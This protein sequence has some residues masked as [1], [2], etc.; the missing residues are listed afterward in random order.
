MIIEVVLHID[1]PEEWTEAYDLSTSEKIIETLEAIGV[2]E[3]ITGTGDKII[4]AKVI[5]KG[6]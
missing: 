3:E 2:A 1:I 5:K 6:G 4:S